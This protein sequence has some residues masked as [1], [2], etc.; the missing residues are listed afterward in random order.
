MATV[1]VETQAEYDALPDKFSSFTVVEIR[2][3]PDSWL[4]VKKCPENSR[5][6]AW[7]SSRVVARESSRVVARESSRVEAW[8]SSS[9]EAWESSRVVAWGSSRVVAWGSSSVV[10]WGSS[11]VEAWESSRVVAWGSSSVVARES[12]SVVARESSRV[13]AWESSSVV[14]RESSRVVAWGTACVHLHSGVP[15]NLFMF[16]VCYLMKECAKA[17]KKSKTATI[18]KPVSPQGVNGW[19]ESQAIKPVAE[20]ILYKRVSSDLKTQEGTSNETIWAIG[21]T[22]EVKDWRPK[23]EECG[24]GKLHA[25]SRPYFC[26]EFRDKA[27]DRYIAIKVKKSDLYAWPNPEYP[28][29]IALR[30]AVVAYECDR[31]GDEVKSN[32]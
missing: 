3:N 21:S 31:F 15:A 7:G 8:E 25:C 29:K 12:S 24:A 26:D 18:I 28:H 1:I 2:S 14:A 20:V 11:R 17:V 10:A 6:V 32:G 23:D 30:K 22:V 13:E 9:V 27:G 4:T 16:A 5:V 19:L